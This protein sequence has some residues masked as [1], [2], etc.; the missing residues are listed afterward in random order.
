[1][2]QSFFGIESGFRVIAQKT[3]IK[4][5]S[6][7]GEFKGLKEKKVSGD[8]LEARGPPGVNG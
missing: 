5:I 2:F 7:K 3:K 4:I 8:R 1:M 6:S